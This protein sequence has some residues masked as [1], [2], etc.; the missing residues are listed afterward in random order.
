MAVLVL[1]NHILVRHAPDF[2][3]HLRKR[4]DLKPGEMPV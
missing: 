4:V 3:E 1:G 2:P